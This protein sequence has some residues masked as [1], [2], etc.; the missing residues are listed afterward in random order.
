MA[1]SFNL[2]ETG[3]LYVLSLPARTAFHEY[4]QNLPMLS[5]YEIFMWGWIRLAGASEFMTR[6]PSF[7]CF[8]AT[9]VVIYRLVHN[10]T[11]D[12]EKGRDTS[13]VCCLVFAAMPQVQHFATTARAYAPTMLLCSLSMLAFSR[14]H[15]TRSDR[16]LITSGAWLAAAILTKVFSLLQLAALVPLLWT[17]TGQAG[18]ARGFLRK[19]A[20]LASAPIIAMTIQ[21][22]MIRHFQEQT[23]LHQY[24]GD[25]KFFHFQQLVLN[26]LLPPML[27]GLVPLVLVA[28]ARLRN[29][30]LIRQKQA[31]MAFTWATMIAPLTLGLLT[32]VTGSF[33]VSERYII[34]S[35]VPAAVL[36]GMAT[37]SALGFP[38]LGTLTAVHL[39]VAGILSAFTLAADHED[40]R[41]A[42]QIA[43]NMEITEGADGAQPVRA[44]FLLLNSGFFETEHKEFEGSAFVEAPARVYPPGGRIIQ[45][46]AYLKE[47]LIEW[48]RVNLAHEEIMLEQRPILFIAKKPSQ[49]KATLI[50][51]L[52]NRRITGI[53]FNQTQVWL[54]F[55]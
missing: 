34:A 19:T 30:S 11:E 44:P 35:Y 28:W 52:L 50:A 17:M 42:F 4:T 29:L 38:A 45:V 20:L 7:L 55:P 51:R 40:W 25:L 5:A 53:E 26:P 22:P 8:A 41:R 13:Y 24:N 12:D 54:M 2:D 39:T 15:R 6:V 43:R 31:L 21:L 9:M 14:W 49:R 3:M 23:H 27:L 33:L 37:G 1:G 32:W 48:A 10:L 36:A 46:P 18:S 16:E 47:G